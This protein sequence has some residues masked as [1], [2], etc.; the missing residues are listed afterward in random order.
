MLVILTWFVPYGSVL[1]SFSPGERVTI[2]SPSPL[3]C[4]AVIMLSLVASAMA[5]RG[6]P[7]LGGDVVLALFDF[8]SVY[9]FLLVPF[10]ITSL[11][12]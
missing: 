10:L 6:V 7:S 1:E 4:L 9:D 11:N 12:E 8:S 5:T 2:A 3:R